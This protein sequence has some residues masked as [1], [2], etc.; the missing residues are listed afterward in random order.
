M[1]A[2]AGR[3]TLVRRLGQIVG[4][5]MLAGLVVLGWPSSLGGCTTLTIVTGHSME[6][7]MHPG[8]LAITRCGTPQVGDV[9]S[10]RPFTDKSPVV[11]HRII[12]GDG[13]NGWQL[14]G[15]N[16]HFV[17]P[18]TPVAGQVTGVMV[19]YIPNLGGVLSMFRSPMMWV[20][21]LLLA[22]A[23][24]LWPERRPST[25]TSTG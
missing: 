12:G 13:V 25:P 16:N 17:D 22:A 9:V 20:S 4:W 21:L 23:L 19:G 6:P 15:D 3:R 5:A 10:Y 18:F 11:I 7:T 14:Q 1:I 24:V 8:D 2:Q